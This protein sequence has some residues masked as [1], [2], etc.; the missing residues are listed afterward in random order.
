VERSVSA[1]RELLV[2]NETLNGNL[3][4]LA[5]TDWKHTRTNWH[6][7]AVEYFL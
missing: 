5:T 1:K 4:E 6:D 2:D 3:R 7:R